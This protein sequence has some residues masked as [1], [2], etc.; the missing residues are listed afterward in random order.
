[1]PHRVDETTD[2]PALF[3]KLL[4]TS[5]DINEMAGRDGVLDRVEGV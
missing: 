2:P 1:M 3:M 5:I 4:L